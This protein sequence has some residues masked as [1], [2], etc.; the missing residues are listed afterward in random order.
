MRN[1]I[2]ESSAVDAAE[3]VR[4]ETIAMWEQA[5]RLAGEL[6]Y[7]I[8]GSDTMNAVMAQWVAETDAMRA[9]PLMA[10]EVYETPDDGKRRWYLAKKLPDTAVSELEA[11]QH[12]RSGGLIVAPGDDQ[13]A[14]VRKLKEIRSQGSAEQKGARL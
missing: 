4:H 5:E 12:R 6:A 3:A 8:E 1:E 9:R 7:T 14:L 2:I 11:M 13:A 10:W